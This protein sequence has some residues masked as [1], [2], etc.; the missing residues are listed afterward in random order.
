MMRLQCN[1]GYLSVSPPCGVFNSEKIDSYVRL[2]D[3][4]KRQQLHL[5][6]KLTRRDENNRWWC[7]KLEKLSVLVKVM[8]LHESWLGSSAGD[9]KFCT[10]SLFDGPCLLWR[11]SWWKQRWW[12]SRGVT[13]G[14]YGFQLGARGPLLLLSHFPWVS[15]NENINLSLRIL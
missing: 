8:D 6:S 11:V 1:S 12:H 13:D 2:A 3:T 5:R 7:Y 14:C 4:A 10:G 9:D 15:A